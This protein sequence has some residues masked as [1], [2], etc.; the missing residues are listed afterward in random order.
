MIASYTYDEAKEQINFY[1]CTQGPYWNNIVG[2]ILRQVA[3]ELGEDEANRLIQE[4]Q[5]TKYGWKEE[6]RRRGNIEI[7]SLW[8]MELP[9][10]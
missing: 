5:L 10:W 9:Q 4:C 3:S 7:K 2:S 8:R 6:E 1:I